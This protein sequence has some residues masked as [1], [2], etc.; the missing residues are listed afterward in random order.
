MRQERAG[1]TEGLA[2]EMHHG[3]SGGDESEPLALWRANLKRLFPPQ[4][5]PRGRGHPKPQDDRAV[6]WP[7]SNLS[8]HVADS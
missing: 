1:S 4:Q 5:L 3:H 8:I 7:H 2:A 6:R